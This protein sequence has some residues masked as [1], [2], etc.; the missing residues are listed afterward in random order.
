M[1][2]LKTKIISLLAAV[3]MICAMIPMSALADEKVAKIGDTEYS[4]LDEAIAAAKDGDIIELLADA[5]TEAGFGLKGIELTV[6]GKNHNIAF[7]GKTIYLAKAGDIPSELTFENCIIDMTQTVGTPTVSGES[8]PWA[9]VVLNWDCKLNL[10]NTI[11][12][13]DGSTVSGSTGVYMHP[14]AGMSLVDSTMTAENYA[15]N[16][17]STDDGNYDVSVTLINSSMTLNKNRTGFNSNYV[18][19]AKDDS[20]LTVTNSRA[21]GS[22]GADYFIDNSKVLYDGN[23]SHGMSSRNVVITNGSKVTSNNNRYY[24]VYVNGSGEFLVDSTSSLTTNYNGYAGL[25]LLPSDVKTGTVES[26]ARVII[27]GNRS[28]GFYNQ[29]ATTFEEGSYLEIMLNYD[30]GNGGGIYNTGDLILPSDAVI[31]NNHASKSG[32][33]IYSTGTITVGEVGHGWAL[34]GDPDCEHMIDG[35]YHDG[36]DN[37]WNVIVEGEPCADGRS[38]DYYEEY[39]PDG[40]LEGTLAIK[41]AHGKDPSDKTSFPGLEKWI[42]EDEEK[43]ESTSVSRGDVVDFE[44]DSNVPQDLKNYLEPDDADAPALMALFDDDIN[45]GV[46][47]IAFNDIMDKGLTLNENSIK[48]TVNGKEVVVNPEIGTDDDGNTTIYVELELISLYKDGYFTEDDFGT[49][50]II[51]TY[52]A[53]AN[54]DMKAGTY[55]NEAWVEYEGGKT[56]HDTV[57]IDTYKISIFKYDQDTATTE[58][59]SWSAKGLGGAEF[60]LKDSYGNLIKTLTS[61]ADGYAYYEGIKAGEYTLTEIEAPE[62]YV[63]SDI[64]LTILVPT[65]SNAANA[66][67]VKFANAL[68]PHTGGTGTRMYTIIGICIIAAAGVFFVISRRKD[69]NS[70]N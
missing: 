6:D 45:G 9:A 42:L 50:P 18:I 4:T 59:D 21:H 28:D 57:E 63:K 7:T 31:Y 30:S 47:K 54:E 41:A 33:D 16:G 8:Y 66:V 2:N 53:I 65:N 12:D 13:M 35:W 23:G 11:L 56:S 69:E 38:E 14:G 1:K 22:N 70:G 48:V 44:L 32:D 60:E 62:G 27:D 43:M 46:Y 36:A 34:D 10:V 25:R 52:S 3:L 15:G 20:S 19:T 68:I 61:N 5:E 51:L 26:G 29:R 24:G 64:P 55:I 58:G 39:I 37:R 40:M 49:A 17:F 67:N